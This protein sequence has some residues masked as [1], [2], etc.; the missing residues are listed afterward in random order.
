MN[1]TLHI[2]PALLL[3]LRRRAEKEN[4]SMSNL[5]VGWVRQELTSPKP[6]PPSWDSPNKAAAKAR[7]LDRPHRSALVN[8]GWSADWLDS[9]TRKQEET[10]LTN[11]Q[12][13]D[14]NGV[15]VTVMT[16]DETQAVHEFTA[17]VAP[18]NS[19]LGIDGIDF[20]E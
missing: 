3:Q 8:R 11:G 6:K 2:P 16:T 9:I 19:E 7:D 14:A 4:R 1:L 15:A 18:S 13:P 20:E 17:A 12:L 5:V 10:L